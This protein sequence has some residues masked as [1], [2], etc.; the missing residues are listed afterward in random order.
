MLRLSLS[1]LMGLVAVSA[2]GLAAMK[3]GSAAASGVATGIMVTSLA[4]ASLGAMVRTSPAAPWRGFAVFGGAYFIVT[5][6]RPD[7]GWEERSPMPAGALVARAS[8]L[9]HP[10][11][12]RPDVLAGSVTPRIRLDEQGNPVIYPRSSPTSA[13]VSERE[14]EEARRYYDA[15]DAYNLAFRERDK[16]LE[17]SRRIAHASLTVASGLVG[18]VVGRA[19]APSPGGRRPSALPVDP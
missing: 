3:A 12:E 10:I 9:L 7:L 1:G 16:R 14:L 4:V 8:D 19:M 15:R 2:I 18:A 11:P 13:P 5:F 6:L 17:N